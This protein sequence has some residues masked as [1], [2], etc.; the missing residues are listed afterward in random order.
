[1][2]G[3]QQLPQGWSPLDEA[4]RARAGALLVAR[5][6]LVTRTSPLTSTAPTAADLIAVAEY[7]IHGAP[8]G[9]D[10]ADTIARR[11]NAV[12]AAHDAKWGTR[13]ARSVSGVEPVDNIDEVGDD[14]GEPGESLGDESAAA[15]L[16]GGHRGDVAEGGEVGAGVG[17]EAA[18][19]GFGHEG[20]SPV[21]GQAPHTPGV[22]EKTVGDAADTPSGVGGDGAGGSAHSAAGPSDPWLGGHSA[23]ILDAERREYER[24]DGQ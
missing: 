8:D 1:M 4:Q 23:E 19:S 9:L 17:D 22:V 5:E 11:I 6:A 24:G 7:V 21:D 3:E 12:L 13:Y 20:S 16:G 10:S 15:R 2:S 14:R 18:D